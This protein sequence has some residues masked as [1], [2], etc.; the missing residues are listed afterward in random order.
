[1]ASL[2]EKI[3]SKISIFAVPRFSGAW[4]QHLIFGQMEAHGEPIYADSDSDLQFLFEIYKNILQGG[5]A[6]L[7]SEYLRERSNLEAPVSSIH[8][9]NAAY[10]AH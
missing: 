7:G 9:R 8:T 6:H 5:S 10:R 2:R 1:M 4:T 3:G